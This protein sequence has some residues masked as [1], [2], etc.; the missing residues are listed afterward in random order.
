MVIKDAIGKFRS[1]VWSLKTSQEVDS[2]T[3]E[4][5]EDSEDSDN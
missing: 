4:E 1:G 5:E 2:N 3:E